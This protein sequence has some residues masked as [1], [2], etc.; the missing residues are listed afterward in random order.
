[1][2]PIA[3]PP[4]RGGTIIPFP[5]QDM[6]SAGGG[7]LDLANIRKSP[8]EEMDDAEESAEWQIRI[9]NDEPPAWAKRKATEM[10]EEEGSSKRSR[11]R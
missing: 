4:P 6:T 3:L 5:L 8:A 11:N 9:G 1:M 7:P 2:H 10:E